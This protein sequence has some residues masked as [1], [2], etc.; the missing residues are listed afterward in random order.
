[1]KQETG[2]N[3]WDWLVVMWRM[4]KYENQTTKLSYIFQFNI[5]V[6]SAS[7][8]DRYFLLQICLNYVI[9]FIAYVFGSKPSAISYILLFN[10]SQHM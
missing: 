5:F 6:Q 4:T 10:R 1:M 8:R 7:Q 3:M 2:T 9:K